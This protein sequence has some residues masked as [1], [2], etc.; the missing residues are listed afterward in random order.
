[1]AIFIF[2]GGGWIFRLELFW[3]MTQ[4]YVII[5]FTLRSNENVYPHCTTNHTKPHYI[6]SRRSPRNRNCVSL[7]R[8][9]LVNDR[10][11]LILMEPS[12]WR[13]TTADRLANV[14]MPT[15]SKCTVFVIEILSNIEKGR[16]ELGDG[17]GLG[18]FGNSRLVLMAEWKKM[19]KRRS[20]WVLNENITEKGVTQRQHSAMS[21]ASFGIYYLKRPL[22]QPVL[23]R[24]SDEKAVGGPAAA[25]KQPKL[26]LN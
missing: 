7:C 13:G 3:V 24:L 10:H 14:P 6:G 17:R 21:V 20:G 4:F 12:T 15:S 26:A 2:I 8:Q 1:M 25:P 5:S 16:G 9:Q 22:R 11:Y 23:K 19:R 18:I